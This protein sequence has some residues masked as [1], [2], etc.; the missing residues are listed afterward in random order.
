[1]TQSPKQISNINQKKINEKQ[2]NEKKNIKKEDNQK[3]D[4]NEPNQIE[5]K[6][7]ISPQIVVPKAPPKYF[8]KS[9]EEED[10]AGFVC[11]ITREIMKDPVL[12]PKFFLREGSEQEV[13]TCERE[14]F[15]NFVM[16]FK[17]NPFSF[18]PLV[19][20]MQNKKNEIAASDKMIE[21]ISNLI[22]NDEKKKEIEEYLEL[23]PQ[24][25]PFWHNIHGTND[26]NNRTD[27][28]QQGSTIKEKERPDL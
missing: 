16:N 17:R 1:M 25:R 28:N 9:A 19:E 5:E 7:Q 8:L 24:R 3:D 6:Q 11:P 27:G 18:E 21:I 10:E 26:T 23:Y 22:Q 14:F 12:A 13:I 20:D 2:S 4:P 15:V